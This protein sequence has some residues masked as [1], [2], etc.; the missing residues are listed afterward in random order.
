MWKKVIAIVSRNLLITVAAI[1]V[2]VIAL[3]WYTRYENRGTAGGEEDVQFKRPLPQE[4]VPGQ[5]PYEGTLASVI[6]V[7]PQAAGESVEIT[8]AV[9][10]K[11][12]F[13]VIREL[14]GG[15]AGRILGVSELLTAGEVLESF[16]VAAKVEADRA[17]LAALHIDNGDGKWN[18]ADDPPF[19]DTSGEPAMAEFEV[20]TPEPEIVPLPS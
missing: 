20:F 17:Y 2:F 5:V 11:P 13:A 4:A 10:A 8:F 14:R 9:V 7:L 15:G 6:D 19:Y 12:G 1:A 3:G 16:T 18:E